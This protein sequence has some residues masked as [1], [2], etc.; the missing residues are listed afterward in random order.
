MVS[1]QTNTVVFLCDCA[2]EDRREIIRQYISDAPEGFVR[3]GSPFMMFF[4]F[5]ALAR[6][7]DFQAI[8]DLS[9]ERWGFMLDKDATTCWETFP[10]FSGGGRWTRSHCHAWSAAPTYFLSAYQ[11][12][13][14]PLESGFS[15]ALIAPEPA[16]LQWAYGR[17][18]TPK[19][20]ISVSW[21]KGDDFQIDVSLPVGVA[22][23]I[24]IPV[25]PEE[26]PDLKVDSSVEF[27]QSREKEY[28]A[29]QV[30]QGAQIRAIASP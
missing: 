28:W 14:R 13:V 17:V 9:R 18:P 19:G 20:T 8:L 6:I 22:A 12:G 16:D 3:V 26:F 7:G 11:L 29:I 2:T 15:L 1:Q 10:G 25:R 23:Q 5:E 24:Q 21:R 27:T 30:G 4:T